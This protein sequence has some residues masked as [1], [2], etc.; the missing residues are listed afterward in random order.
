MDTGSSRWKPFFTAFGSTNWKALSIHVSIFF[1]AAFLI[2]VLP[3]KQR[4]MKIFFTIFYRVPASQRKKQSVKIIWYTLQL[5]RDSP[6]QKLHTQ[7]WTFP[8]N[9][10]IVC[11]LRRQITRLSGI[12][13][14]KI[15]IF[16]RCSIYRWK[17]TNQ[18]AI[19]TFFHHLFV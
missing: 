15:Q 19:C 14:I 12:Y 10:Q 18:D 4:S 17:I 13:L 16:E 5:Q 1:W 11:I 9:S 6:H 3:D 7:K 8:W 2:R